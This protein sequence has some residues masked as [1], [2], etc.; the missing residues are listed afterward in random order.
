MKVVYKC[1]CLR[2]I[3][4]LFGLTRTPR[5]ICECKRWCIEEVLRRG[6]KFVILTGTLSTRMVDG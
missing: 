6:R 2:K 5:S 3:E 1:E 4:A